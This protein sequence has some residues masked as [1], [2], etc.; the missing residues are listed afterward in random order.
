MGEEKMLMLH[1]L[2]DFLR[3]VSYKP[4][5]PAIKLLGLWF[6]IKVYKLPVCLFQTFTSAYSDN[7]VM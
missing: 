1:N 4:V 6:K 7:S 3:F 5:V 2:E